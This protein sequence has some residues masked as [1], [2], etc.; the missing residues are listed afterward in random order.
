MRNHATQIVAVDFFTVP[1]VPFRVLFVFVVLAHERRKI[2]H[3]AITEAPSAGWT[4]QQVVEAFA[5]EPASKYLLW[6]RDGI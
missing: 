3:F 4:A 1:T 2:R 6:D 5:F